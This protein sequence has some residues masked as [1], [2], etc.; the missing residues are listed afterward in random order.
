MAGGP[1]RHRVPPDRPAEGR[2][3]ADRRRHVRDLCQPLPDPAARG[4]CRRSGDR[5]GAAVRHRLGRRALSDAAQGRAC[6]PGQP[7]RA[8]ALPGRVLQSGAHHQQRAEVGGAAV[9]NNFEQLVEL[10]RSGKSFDANDQHIVTIVDWLWQYAFEQRAS[11]IHMEPRRDLG[12]VRFRIDGVLHN[13]YQ[14][15]P[16]RPVGDDQPHQAAGPDGRGREAPTAGR[17]DQDRAGNGK[18]IELRL[19]TMPTAFGEKLVM[20]IFDPDVLVLDFAQLGFGDSDLRRW[21][22]MTRRPNGIVLV[23]GPTG[24]GKT[25]TLYTTLKEL[26]IEEVNV[27]TRRRSDRDGRAELQPDAGPVVD[28]PDVRGRH[29]RADAPGSGHHHGRRDPRPRDRRDGDP[30]G[31]DRPPRPLDIAYQRCPECD[32][33]DA[34][35]GRAVVPDQLDP[36]RRDGAAAGAHAVPA[37]QI[38]HR[39]DRRIRL[40]DADLAVS[41]ATAA[42]GLQARRLSRMP[43]DG[44]PWPDRDLRDPA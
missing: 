1:A 22:E 19:S 43:D 30:G 34:R 9:Q 40:E 44:L 26:A 4:R 6:R 21:H 14:V 15:P 39:R 27:T 8:A 41:G 24:S 11:D 31:T 13:V 33:A 16:W 7:D 3:F 17:P 35:P 10:G 18:E 20:R 23:T 28:R 42:T 5:H 38:R 2:L 32:H 36:D 37:L 29:P 12:V 25:T